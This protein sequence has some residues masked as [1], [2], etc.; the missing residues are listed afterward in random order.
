MLGVMEIVCCA[1]VDIKCFAVTPGF[2]DSEIWC[3][4]ML[5]SGTM[6]W[7]DESLSCMRV[8]VIRRGMSACTRLALGLIAKVMC[9]TPEQACRRVVCA[10]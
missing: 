2:V 6:R 3:S 4:P 9:L 5:C 7:M 1:G 10:M 8:C